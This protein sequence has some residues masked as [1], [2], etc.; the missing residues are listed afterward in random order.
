MLF[1]SYEFIFIFLPIVLL[2]FHLIGKQGHH[3]VAIAWLV[4][5]SL[6][7]YGWWNPAYLSLILFSI[8]FN[9]SIG[10]SMSNTS[11][12]KLSSKVILTIG[13]A[14]N[15]A[16]LGYYKYANFFVDNLNVLSDSNL[17]LHKVILPLAISFFTFQQIAYLID[18]YRG[19]TREYS[20]LL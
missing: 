18:A 7:F 10:I 6:F 8:L 15:L 9:Y 17:I 4:G 20:F 11:G 5:A 1:N 3:R 12:H 13:V 14:T 16:V 2:V 19:E